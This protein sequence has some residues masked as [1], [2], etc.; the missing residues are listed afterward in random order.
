MT[1]PMTTPDHTRSGR[2]A[3]PWGMLLLTLCFLYLGISAW[4]EHDQAW[5]NQQYRNIEYALHDLH[6]E[7]EALRLQARIAAFSLSEDPDTRRLL[8]RIHYLVRLYGLQDPEVARLRAQLMDDLTGLW[9]MLQEAGAKEL[10]IHLTPDSVALL[11]MQRPERWADQQDARRPLLQHAQLHGEAIDGLALYPEGASESAVIPVFAS[12]ASNSRVI[13]TLQIGFPVFAHHHS[14]DQMALALLVRPEDQLASALQTVQPGRWLLADSHGA[15]DQAMARLAIQALNGTPGPKLFVHDN[16][17][18]LAALQPRDA[19]RAD[20]TLSSD[21]VA[22]LAWKDLTDSYAIHRSAMLRQ[23]GSW[24]LAWLVAITLF[25]MLLLYSRNTA[26]RQMVQHAEAISA[27]SQRREH[28]RRLLEIISQSQSD[29]IQQNDFAAALQHLLQQILALTHFTRADFFQARPDDDGKLQLLQLGSSTSAPLPDALQP[30]LLRVLREAHPEQIS[31]SP[32][33]DLPRVLALPLMFAGR[34]RGVLALSGGDH[35]VDPELRT[36]LAPL[37][38]ALGQLLH[39]QRQQQDNEAMQHSLE[40]QRQ[41]LRQLNRL[42]ADPALNL[43]Q[44]LV[45]LLDLGCDYLRLDLGLVSYVEEDRYRVEAA[46]STEDAPPVGTLF[47]FDK[48]YCRLTWQSSDVLAIDRMGQSRFSGH[49]CYREFGLESY[50]GVALIVGDQRF[51]TLNFSSASPR[52]QRFDE[53]DTDFVR[54]CGRWCSSLLEQAAAQHQREALLQRFHK[55]TQHLPGMV[56]QYQV[57]QSGHGWFPYASEGIANIYDMTPEQAALDAQPAIDLIHPDDLPMVQEDIRRSS[58]ERNEWRSEYRVRHSRL[59]EIWVA[60]YASPEPLENGDLVWHGFIADISERKQIEQ[61][62]NEERARLARII[63]ATHVGTWEWRLDNNTLEASPRWYQMLGYQP[64]ELA[65]LSIDTWTSLIHP[66]DVPAIRAQ[67]HAHLRG[68]SEHLSYLCRARHRDGR[69]IWVQSQGQ[70]TERDAAGH[71]LAMS[72]IH[73]DVSAEVHANEQ[74]REARSYLSAVINAS[75]EVAIIAVDPDGVI[76]LFN[77]GAQRLLGYSSEEVVGKLTPMQFHLPSEVAERSSQLSAQVGKPIEG[78]ELF[79]HEPRQGK[80]DIRAWTYVRKDGRQRQVRLTVTRIAD[81]NDQLIGFLGM[82]SDITELVYTSR[83]LQNSESRYR[84]MVSNLPGAVYRCHADEHWTMSYMSQEIER[85]SG[86][87]AADFINN[88]RRSYASIIVPD[89]LPL[90]LQ[91]LTLTPDNPNFELSYRLIHAKGQQVQVRE[92]GRGE[93]DKDGQLLGFD[94][95]IWDAT[96]QA[97]V[98]QMKS[99]FVSTVS[100]EL[101]TPLTAI[102]GSLKLIHGGALGQLPDSMQNLLGVAVQNSETLHR[103]I[104][105]LLDMD[106][107]TAGKLQIELARQPLEPLLQRALQLN[108]SY[109]VQYD[110]RQQLGQVDEVNVNVDAQRLGQVLANYL[111]NAAKFSNAGNAITLSAV[112]DNGWVEISVEDQ[113]IGIPEQE[114]PRIF[115]KF[116]Q[117]DSSTTRKRA[118]S[119]LGLAISR[120]LA[121]R[122]GGDVGFVSTAGVGSRFWIRLPVANDTAANQQPLH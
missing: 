23:A 53:A 68:D 108:Q 4:Q 17:I 116:F 92:K 105:D 8:R 97:R 77:T 122:M 70:V 87:P 12:R 60:G 99:Q 85:I 37:Q 38:T 39:A 66:K 32:D 118:G 35:P 56:Y 50:I 13:A 102:I 107:L 14:H 75:T 79:L 86:Y 83:A 112:A 101:R 5:H 119:G 22:L 100:H 9:R 40:R 11:R 46:S 57:N 1:A 42:A 28:D 81:D 58:I 109:A 54:L 55:L 78:L 71:A 24:L 36:F 27:Q 72:G 64:E 43:Q 25:A 82:A 62:L 19:Y 63:D 106:K 80:S 59:G 90:T 31:A 111:S 16:R 69:W 2:L 76:T 33:R 88:A 120:E 3:L 47:D 65:P 20:D 26:R 89:D 94:G 48:T 114:Q 52:S 96:E 67:L 93:F 44:R 6:Q 45:Q 10:Q 49:P 91:C 34:Q 104:N 95:F 30:M 41:A 15:A 113:G 29:Y 18:W 73:S 117:V 115:D 74:S 98:E 7:Q 121:S 21:D 110:V 61:R 103:L 84:G 51:G